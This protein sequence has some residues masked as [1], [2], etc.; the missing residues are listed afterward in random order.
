MDAEAVSDSEMDALKAKLTANRK[1]TIP[2][3]IATKKRSP[4]KPM[5]VVVFEFFFTAEL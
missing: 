3:V 1:E 5:C 4:E 2:I